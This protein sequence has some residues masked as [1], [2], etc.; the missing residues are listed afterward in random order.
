MVATRATRSRRAMGSGSSARLDEPWLALKETYL[1][2]RRRRA[3]PLARL[4]LSVSDFQCLDLC[5]R[6]PTRAS[7]LARSVGVT[8]AG[9]TDMIDR[10]VRQRLVSRTHDP[11]DGRVVLVRLTPAGG[12]VYRNAK[13]LERVAFRR[14]QRRLTSPERRAL[15]TGLTALRRAAGEPSA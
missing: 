11:D 5:A 2:V 7:A 14:L 15:S 9:A 1:L 3:A 10:L 13:V 8:P 4:G 12:R 6:S